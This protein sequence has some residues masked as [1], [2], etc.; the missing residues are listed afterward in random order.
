MVFGDDERAPAGAPDGEHFD[1]Y[2]RARQ[3][4][5][6]SRKAVRDVYAVLGPVSAGTLGPRC[7]H[8]GSWQASHSMIS[9]GAGLERLIFSPLPQRPISGRSTTIRKASAV[10]SRTR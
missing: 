5:L 2:L 7:A 1:R 10:S 8:A 4:G 3:E 9:L 6:I